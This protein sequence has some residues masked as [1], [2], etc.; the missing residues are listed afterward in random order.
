MNITMERLKPWSNILHV[1]RMTSTEAASNF[2]FESID[3]IFLDAR[4]D[5]CATKADMDLYW[6]FVKKGG[7]FGGH[8]YRTNGTSGVQK[9]WDICE[10][11]SLVGGAVKRAVD[12]FA[13]QHALVISVAYDDPGNSWF[14]RKP[15]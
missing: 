12:E 13:V 6:P 10:D 3:F 4:H 11:G 15:F 2:Q 7:I 5:Y 1:H 8:D 9:Y 14:V